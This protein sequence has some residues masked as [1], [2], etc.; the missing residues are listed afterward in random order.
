MMWMIHNLWHHITEPPLPIAMLS[1]PFTTFPHHH[2]HAEGRVC[3]SQR[4]IA[5]LPHHS[6]QL[7]LVEDNGSLSR[8]PHFPLKLEGSS[9]VGSG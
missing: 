6:P 1:Y 3:H 5:S 4:V 9:A 2:D 7:L 8:L